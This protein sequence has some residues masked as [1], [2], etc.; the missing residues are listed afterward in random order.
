MP[1]AAG[2]R[3]ETEFKALL[4]KDQNRSCVGLQCFSD[5]LHVARRAG[6]TTFHPIAALWES[7][8]DGLIVT[9]AEPTARSISD[10]PL[11][12]LLRQLVA[13]GAQNTKSIIFSCFAAHAAVWCLDGVARVPLAEKLSGVFHCTKTA[14]HPFTAAM[15]D[16][17]IVPH[18]RHNTLEET[19]LNAAGYVVL[20]GAPHLGPDLFVK[21]H[22]HCEMLF[23]QGH[24]EYGPDVLL[25][26]YRR[27][28]KRFV[29][30]VTSRAPNWPANYLNDLSRPVAGLSHHL[31]D[32]VEVQKELDRLGSIEESLLEHPWKSTASRLM[33]G[34]LGF[35]AG[36][37]AKCSSL[38]RPCI[39]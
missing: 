39:I 27:D 9:G 15:P 24:L 37:N 38:S 12:P 4:F 29:N 33:S 10:E 22:G 1:A 28:L 18:S 16:S 35:L 19:T 31:N 20:S 30:G 2:R 8:L 34:W 32:L 6:A 36:Q 11:L 5:A 26:E 7:Q 13:W 17:W 14:D 25:G 3:T 21:R 23:A